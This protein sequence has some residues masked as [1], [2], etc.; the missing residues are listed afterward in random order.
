M[1]HNTA[2]TSPKRPGIIHRLLNRSEFTKN[3]ATLMSGTVA[4]QIVPFLVQPL[5]GRLFTPAEI[6]IFTAFTSVVATISTVAAG[7]YDLAIVLPDSDDDARGL[8][9]LA[10]RLNT[11][12]CAA[13]VVL[14]WVLAEPICAWVNQPQ[15]KTWLPLAGLAAWLF[16]QIQVHA[17][18]CNR[19][20]MYRVMG[21]NKLT[22]A[23][24]LNLTQ[25]GLGGLSKLP[26]GPHLGVHG[27]VAGT[28]VGYGI[29]AGRIISKTWRSIRSGTPSSAKQMAYEFRKMPILN[30]PNAVVDAIRLNG[31][32]LL[33][34]RYF[35]A[36]NLGQF[37]KAWQ[38]LQVPMALINT[39]L[40]QVFYQ[41]MSTTKPGQMFRMV[42]HGMVRSFLIGIVPFTVI[43]FI[44]PMLMPW[45]LGPM[46]VDTGYIARIL[47]PWLFLNFITS[48]VSLMFL[49][50]KRQGTM[51]IFSTA[52][53][54]VPLV[55]LSVSSHD[56]WTALTW[57]S[58]SMAA[59]LVVFM[60]MALW[61]ARSWDRQA[62]TV[63][64]DA[65]ATPSGDATTPSGDT[66]A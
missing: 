56:F 9:T 36:S 20:K 55:I 41:Q 8:V 30:G 18:W 14:L 16:S 46:W 64:P 47:V 7:R 3:L 17:Y 26:S 4:A 50:V 25:V 58:W 23:M 21:G 33:I 29:G 65:T 66:E 52:Y 10:T 39:S 2:S 15:L 34:S 31:I 57:M 54:V 59:M 48:P 51:L 37:G 62:E 32:P 45:Y 5:I 35:G 1:V 60:V 24:A 11:V 13:S 27:L 38:L 28:I 40:S 12:V 63:D 22:Q 6:G 44:S 43:W 19:L 61:V 42:R 53:M 49:V